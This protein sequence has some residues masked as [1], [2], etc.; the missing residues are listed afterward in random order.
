MLECTGTE[1]LE[2][3]YACKEDLSNEPPQA[4]LP[5]A[6]ESGEEPMLIIGAMAG[7]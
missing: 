7:G 4:T 1:K 6:V 2:S 3:G 5:G